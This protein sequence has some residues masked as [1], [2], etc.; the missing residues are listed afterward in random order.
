MT[1]AL[2]IA[3]NIFLDKNIVDFQGVVGEN[4]EYEIIIN[5]QKMKTIARK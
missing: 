5:Q 2:D 3:K 4:F 1:K